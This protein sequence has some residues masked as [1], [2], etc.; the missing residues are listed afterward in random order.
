MRWKMRHN[1]GVASI[2]KKKKIKN[3]RKAKKIEE[4][5]T[6]RDRYNIVCATRLL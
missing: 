2:K 6:V 4:A 5:W 3:K 1:L